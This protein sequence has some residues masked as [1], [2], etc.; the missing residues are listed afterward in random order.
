MT[1]Q[2]SNPMTEAQR[3]AAMEDLELIARGEEADGGNLPW[4]RL[5]IL[6]DH[7][8]VEIAF[9]VVTFG[10]N[11]SLDITRDGLRWLGLDGSLRQEPPSPDSLA[12]LTHSKEIQ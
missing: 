11:R 2:A 12:T 1:K 6:L 5:R 8:L 10:S 7:D 9:P 4:G 3:Q